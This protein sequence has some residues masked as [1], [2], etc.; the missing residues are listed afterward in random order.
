L[1]ERIAQ[2][3]SEVRASSMFQE[4][5]FREH[6]SRLADDELARIALENELVPEAQRALS[7]ELQ[8]RRL[9]DLSKYKAALEQAADERSLGRQMEIQTRMEQQF[10]EWMFTL[11]GW[12]FGH[13]RANALAAMSASA[14]FIA[15]THG[16]PELTDQRPPTVE[17]L[18]RVALRL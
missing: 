6:Y 3:S 16:C 4:L 11:M 8:K 1:L 14:I 9:T 15:M 17:V 2:A 10:V 5:Q 18:D 7:E 12:I 13:S